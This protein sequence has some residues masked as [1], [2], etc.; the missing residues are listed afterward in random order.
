LF[1]LQ[2]ALTIFELGQLLEVGHRSLVCKSD[3]LAAV[4]VEVLGEQ[5]DLALVDLR[6]V[7]CHDVL[8]EGGRIG[9]RSVL[10]L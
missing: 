6:F 8:E 9:F 5:L 4:L 7:G 1:L 2:R 3:C 10:L